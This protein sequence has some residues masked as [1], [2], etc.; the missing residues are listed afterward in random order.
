MYKISLNENIVSRHYKNID[1]SIYY[2]KKSKRFIIL[3]DVASTVCRLITKFENETLSIKKISGVI[4][5]EF[6]CPKKSILEK[7]ILA[8]INFLYQKNLIK[9]SSLKDNNHDSSF[10]NLIPLK[11]QTPKDYIKNVFSTPDEIS[12]ITNNHRIPFTVTFELTNKCPLNCI[13]CYYPNHQKAQWDIEKFGHVLDELK[14]LGTMLI[15][16]SGGECLLHPDIERFLAL[17]QEK[18]FITCL[19]TNGVL[20]TREKAKM[21]ASYQ[22][23]NIQLSLYA[24]DAETHDHITQIKGSFEKTLKAIEYLREEGIN[25]DIACSVMK[26]NFHAIQDLLTWCQSKN[27][28][29]TFNFRIFPSYNS[30]KKSEQL[31]C[32]KEPQIKS[33]LSN[34]NFNWRLKRILSKRRN[35]IPDKSNIEKIMIRRNSKKICSGGFSTFCINPEGDVFPCSVLRLKVGNVFKSSLKDI[36]NHSK[37]LKEWRNITIDDFQKCKKCNAVAFCDICPAAEFI[38][39]G[40]LKMIDDQTCFLEKTT[41]QILKDLGV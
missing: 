4:R 24:A 11:K 5:K 1:C 36:W 2:N 13:H 34:E 37:I 30:E 20:I 19:L 7:D 31:N 26:N 17:S 14:E 35:L 3:K 28:T 15:G 40:K 23:R 21:I 12:H 33:I 32:L 27:L 39:T 16:F 18:N 38:K 6:N 9:L 8:I 25:P 41:Y 22:P 29:C 10:T